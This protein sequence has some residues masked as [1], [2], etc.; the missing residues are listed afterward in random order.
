[1]VVTGHAPVQQKQDRAPSKDVISPA[2]T[3][4]CQAGASAKVVTGQGPGQ[5]GQ[6]GALSQVVV[7]DQGAVQLG[8]SG[9]HTQVPEQLEQAGASSQTLKEQAP[10]QLGQLET[11]QAP[12]LGEHEE[13]FLADESRWENMKEEIPPENIVVEIEVSDFGDLDLNKMFIEKGQ[14]QENFNVCRARADGRCGAHCI[15]IHIYNC[16]NREKEVMK[17]LNKHIIEHWELNKNSFSFPYKHQIG[18]GREAIFENEKDLKEFIQ[19][20]PEASSFW[21][22]HQWLQA[23]ASLYQMTIHVL[24]TGINAPRWNTLKPDPRMTLPKPN[25]IKR[26]DDMYLLHSNDS[27]FDLLVP[28]QLNNSKNIEKGEAVVREVENLRNELA[29]SKEEIKSLKELLHNVLPGDAFSSI[30]QDTFSCTTCEKKYSTRE[31]LWAHISEEHTKKYDCDSCD[32]SFPNEQGLKNHD[33]EN[34]NKNYDCE[35]CDYQCTTKFILIKH[36]KVKHGSQILE[37][38]GVGAKKC[39]KS[40]DPYNDLM[41]HRRDDHNSGNISCRYF[42]EG[43]CQ[44]TDGE[45]EVCWYLHTK[46]QNRSSETSGE[47]PCKSC[48]ESFS[49]QRD[50]IMH[51]KIRHEEEVSICNKISEGKKCSR[52]ERCWFIHPKILKSMTDHV[53]SHVNLNDEEAAT[54]VTKSQVFWKNLSINKPP[55][56]MEKVIQMLNTVMTE[57]SELKKQLNYLSK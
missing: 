39:G 14:I 38:K 2:P 3:Q 52:N 54:N 7:A 11:G 50:V 37:C 36:N 20:N 4:H 9:A 45:K 24:T 43:N 28:K 47:F 48:D 56:Q 40:F 55:D 13:M 34:H 8:Q 57:V 1:M 17:N 23:A 22:D 33:T 46:G 42:K 12:A 35:Q 5:S 41:N 21:V 49:N 27:H 53:A 10:I 30:E 44:Y 16:E 51:R 6:V 31:N 18:I 25:T 19:H 26:I 32:E 29:K 15:S